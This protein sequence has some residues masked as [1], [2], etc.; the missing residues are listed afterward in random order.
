MVSVATQEC[1]SSRTDIDFGDG[2][3]STRTG[4]WDN[5]ISSSWTFAN[6]HVRHFEDPFFAGARTVF[7]DGTSYIGDAMNDRTS[8][9]QWT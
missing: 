9:L 4:G 6:C 7:Q 3:L 5:R 8:S 1:T 2:D